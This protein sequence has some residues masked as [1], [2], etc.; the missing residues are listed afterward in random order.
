MMH[1]SGILILVA[2]LPT[3]HATAQSTPPAWGANLRVVQELKIGQLEG[4][5]QYTFGNIDD[6]AVGLDGSI[7]VLDGGRQPFIRMYD[8]NGKFVRLVG[9]QGEGPGEY[10]QPIAIKAMADGR[11][12]AW[13]PRVRR[14]TV[15]DGKGEYRTSFRV[16]AG[17]FTDDVFAV[18]RDGNFYVK[19][20]KFTADDRSMRSQLWLKVSATGQVLDTIPIPLENSTAFVLMT[21]EG[22]DPP[23]VTS[24]FSTMS[25]LGYL[26][27]GNNTTY[28]FTLVKDGKPLKVER[29]YQPVPVARAEKAEWDAWADRFANA[30][31]ARTVRPGPDGKPQVT[32]EKGPGRYTVPNTKPPYRNLTV[33]DEGRIWVDRHVAAVQRPDTRKPDSKSPPHVWREPRTFDV[34]DPDGKFLGTVVAP[35][36]TQFLVQRGMQLWGVTKGEFDEEY[37]VRYRIEASRRR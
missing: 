34:F 15:Y 21:S 29:S 33:D 22:D 20:T 30:P 7:F 31:G 24:V 3:A 9:R 27:T 28:S 1:R 19:T 36:Q 23:F 18:D 25:P 16:D 2:A 11:I 37:V 10:R 12:A 32:E 13:D 8:P 6:I 35:P 14:V 5:E 4:A 17:L 26:V